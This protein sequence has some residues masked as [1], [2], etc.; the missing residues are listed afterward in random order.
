[1]RWWPKTDEPPPLP[2][3]E[4]PPRPAPPWEQWRRERC[5]VHADVTNGRVVV[6]IGNL[7]LGMTL[8]QVNSLLHDLTLARDAIAPIAP[9]VAE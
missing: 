4:K 3:A 9:K 2:P 8:E 5:E 7:R 1:M 6:D